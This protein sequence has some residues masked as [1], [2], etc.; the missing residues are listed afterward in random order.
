MSTPKNFFYNF[1]LTGS[2]ILFPLITFPYLSR[3]LG[4]EGIGICN[5]IISYSQNFSIIAALGLPIY[6]IRE[7]ARIGDDISRRSKLFFEL[8]TVHMIFTG[9]LLLLYYLS[10]ILISDLQDNKQ[11]AI[12]G[13]IFILLNFLQVEWLFSGVSD[14]KYIALRSLLI[15]TLSITSIFILVK[16]KEDYVIYF[17]ITL[18]TILITAVININY[19]SKYISRDSNLTLKGAFSHLKAISILGIY[20]VLTSIYSVLPMTLIGFFSTKAAVGYYYGADKVIRTV[21]SIFTAL[22]TVLTPKLNQIIEKID[23]N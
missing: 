12:L 10:I 11:L 22:T 2:N 20:V 1:L 9:F 3:M 18:V 16:Q 5:F 19:T 8:L 21:I 4:A 15:R 13:G 7:I 14:F 23:N 6:G 17:I